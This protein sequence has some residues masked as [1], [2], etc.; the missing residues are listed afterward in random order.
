[1]L[2]RR[3]G[4]GRGRPAV[5]SSPA[6]ALTRQ[7]ALPA[8]ELTPGLNLSAFSICSFMARLFLNVDRFKQR[9]SPHAG[10]ADEPCLRA[11]Q[12][13]RSRSALSACVRK[14]RMC[15]FYRSVEL[16]DGGR[17]FRYLYRP[18]WRRMAPVTFITFTGAS[19]T[20]TRPI[21][22]CSERTRVAM[23]SPAGFEPATY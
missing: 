9:P 14:R 11:S 22:G 17:R 15:K 23:V 7:N 19:A 13:C 12:P 2:A 18:I 8:G 4:V 3:Q 21:A 6:F 1:M 10:W 20:M 5:R 16:P